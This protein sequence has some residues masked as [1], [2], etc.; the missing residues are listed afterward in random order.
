MI[1]AIVRYYVCPVA[2]NNKVMSM[3]VLFSRLL[4]HSESLAFLSYHIEDFLN[5]RLCFCG[6]NCGFWTVLWGPKL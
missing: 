6:K 2:K 1:C 3:F 4:G 5:E